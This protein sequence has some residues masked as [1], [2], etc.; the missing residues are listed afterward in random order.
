VKRRFWRCLIAW[1][2]QAVLAIFASVYASHA[3]AA[4]LEWIREIATPAREGSRGIDVAYDIAVDLE[5]NVFAAGVTE[6]SLDGGVVS[7]YDPFI[8]KYRGDGSL[9]WTRQLRFTGE[10]F[11]AVSARGYGVSLDPQGNAFLGGSTGVHPTISQVDALAAKF[12]TD[13]DLIWQRRVDVDVSDLVFAA[14]T[15]ANGG[16]A[17]AGSSMGGPFAQGGSEALVIGLNSDG[18]VAWSRKFGTLEYESLAGITGD[19]LGNYY[20]VGTSRGNLVT[21]VSNNGYYAPIIAKLD[22]HGDI[23]WIQQ[24]WQFGYYGVANGIAVDALGNFYVAGSGGLSEA[25]AEA[26]VLKF[27]P[28]GNQLWA[29]NKGGPWQDAAS[30]IAVDAL[31][32]VYFSGAITNRNSGPDAFVGKLNGH[33]DLLWMEFVETFGNDHAYGIAVDQRGGVYLAGESNLNGFV[34]KFLDVPE[35]RGVVLVGMVLISLGLARQVRQVHW[36]ASS[37]DGRL[38][39]L[40]E[41]Q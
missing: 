11:V 2:A 25:T 32:N 17:M 31:G 12:T 5:G 33:G 18:S 34:A 41:G 38:P 37:R 24:L 35:P 28:N 36:R 15:G 6:G 26:F 3:A 4:R 29:Y 20:V 22:D 16:Y 10:G 14:A 39:L 7:N 40:G 27:D 23:V 8:Q 21:T 1:N 19:D 9:A 30:A 13:G